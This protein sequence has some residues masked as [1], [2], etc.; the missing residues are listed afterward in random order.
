MSALLPEAD[1]AIQLPRWRRIGYFPHGWSRRAAR[2]DINYGPSSSR[3]LKV[4]A[5]NCFPL[6]AR[7]AVSSTFKPRPGPSGSAMYPSTG[8]STFGHR[9]RP[10]S[11]NGRKYSVIMK[12]GMQADAWTEADSARVVEL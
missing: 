9:R 3:D 1:I 7:R 11:S 8:R 10:S 4:L 12:F 2:K 5:G 6:A